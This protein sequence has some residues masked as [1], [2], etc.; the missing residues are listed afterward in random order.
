[1]P[2]WSDEQR[3]DIGEDF[4]M[5]TDHLRVGDEGD[6]TEVVEGLDVLF[7]IENTGNQMTRYTNILGASVGHD[8]DKV[9]EE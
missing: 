3:E 8:L 4:G 6:Q 9:I 1:M 7:V 2:S 5:R